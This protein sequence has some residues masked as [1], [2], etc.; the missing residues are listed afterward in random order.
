M[1][2]ELPEVEDV[3]AV[4]VRGSGDAGE[5]VVVAVVPAAGAAIDPDEV[6]AYARERLTGYKVPRRVLVVDELPRS[7]VGKV[8]R[9]LVRDEIE[10]SDKVNGEQAR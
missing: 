10:A 3:A 1:V 2:R 8:L 5:E 9:R 6:R 4:G 7:Q